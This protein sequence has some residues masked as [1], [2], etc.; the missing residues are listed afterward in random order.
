MSEQPVQ[1]QC[2]GERVDLV[3][4]ENIFNSIL[5]ALKQKVSKK[6]AMKTKQE[7][8]D[9]KRTSWS[10]DTPHPGKYD[11][12]SALTKVQFWKGKMKLEVVLNV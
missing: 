12:V 6:I 11:V 2:W 7:G 3:L 5:V 9:Y 10:F 1:M 8:R 4:D